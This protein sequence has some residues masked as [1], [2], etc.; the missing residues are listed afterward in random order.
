MVEVSVFPIERLLQ[1]PLAPLVEA[2]DGPDGDAGGAAAAQAA[3]QEP[4]KV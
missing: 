1:H 2:E 3:N 4:E